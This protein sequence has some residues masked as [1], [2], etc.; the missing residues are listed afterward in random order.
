MPLAPLHRFW[1]DRFQVFAAPDNRYLFRDWLM[2][3]GKLVSNKQFEGLDGTELRRAFFRYGFVQ[4]AMSAFDRPVAE[5]PAGKDDSLFW[6]FP[7][8][9]E[10]AAWD[11]HVGLHE[12]VLKDGALHIYVGLPWAT[13]VDR[14]RKN[15]WSACGKSVM[16]RQLSVVSVRLSGLRHALSEIGVCLRAHTVCQHIYWQD[17]IP[18]WSKLGI[19]DVWLSH[20]REGE[21]V[22]AGLAMHPWALYAVN[23]EDEERH[24]GIEP[25]KDP[26]SKRVLASFVGAHAGHYLSDV[27]L[28]LLSLSGKEGFVVRVTDKWHFE[29][30]VYRHQMGVASLADSYAI[31]DS[32]TGYNQLLSDSVF[33]LCPSG[34]GPNTLRLWESLAVGAIPVLLG[35]VPVLPSGGSLPE[36]DWGSIVVRVADEQIAD[37]PRLLRSMPKHEVRRRQRLGMEAYAL[38]RSQ[39]CF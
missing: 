36:I 6:Q 23:V 27:R 35:P 10:G 15:A 11:V 30:V 34:A 32:V 17:L 5:R 29:D 16:E 9:T 39:R 26:A 28:R 24:S 22:D 13:W 18:A 19:S 1:L 21:N 38:V 33:S 4:P 3:P 14:E 8:R 12:P 25:G 2:P 7:C 31:G 37:L 20:C